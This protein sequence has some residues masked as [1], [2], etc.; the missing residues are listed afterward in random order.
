MSAVRN[1][2]GVVAAATLVNTAA[3]RCLATRSR[4]SIFRRAVSLRLGRSASSRRLPPST[5]LCPGTRV[6]FAL[7]SAY[8]LISKPGAYPVAPLF[9]LRGRA[10]PPCVL[11]VIYTRAFSLSGLGVG[12]LGAAKKAALSA[13][14]RGSCFSYYFTASHAQRTGRSSCCSVTLNLSYQRHGDK[15][16]VVV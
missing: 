16:V 8:A 13:G 14:W 5:S 10:G 15:L 9:S 7:R 2:S 6:S 12:R 1:R 3:G 11:N 4:L